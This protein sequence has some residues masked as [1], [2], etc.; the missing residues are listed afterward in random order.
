MVAVEA[1]NTDDGEV[2][3]QNE[4]RGLAEKKSGLL[5]FI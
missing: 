2:L 3:E 1:Q 4:D 5:L